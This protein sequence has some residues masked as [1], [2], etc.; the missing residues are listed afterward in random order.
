MVELVSLGLGFAGGL[1]VSYVF[2][3]AVNRKAVSIVNSIKGTKGREIRQNQEEEL[4][5][6]L[7]EAMQLIKTGT[8]PVDALKET[9]A[10]HPAV[11]ARIITKVMKGELPKGMGDLLET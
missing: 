7:G 5:Q 1:L 11:A 8:K 6:A 3:W 10:K 4:F 9:A 2:Q